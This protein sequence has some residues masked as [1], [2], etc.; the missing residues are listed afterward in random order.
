MFRLLITKSKAVRAKFDGKV[1][2]SASGKEDVYADY[3]KRLLSSTIAQSEQRSDRRSSFEPTKHT[4]SHVQVLSQ[5]SPAL[6]VIRKAA[7]AIQKS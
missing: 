2:T 3:E 1:V 4:R 6:D 5:P 7:S